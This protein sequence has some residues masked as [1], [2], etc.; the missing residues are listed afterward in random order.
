VALL[1]I[2]LNGNNT[3]VSSTSVQ[4]LLEELSLA[5]KKVA[6]ELNHQIVPRSSYVSTRLQSGDKLEVVHFVGGG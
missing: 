2:I 3:S 6:V 5:N 4:E 1:E